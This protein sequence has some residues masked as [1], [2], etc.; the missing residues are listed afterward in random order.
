M[1]MFGAMYASL[2]SQ[3]PALLFHRMRLRACE[4]DNDGLAPMEQK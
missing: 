1:F 4:S 3:A 2:P